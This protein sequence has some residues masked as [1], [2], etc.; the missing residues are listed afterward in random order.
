MRGQLTR[1]RG[2]E[3][4][5]LGDGF[6]TTFDGPA[7]AIRC[8]AAIARE[9]A[10]LGLFVRAGLHTGEVELAGDDIRGIAVHAASR[11]SAKA[12]PGEVWTTRTVRDLVAGSGISFV[13]RGT[14]QLKGLREAMPL[15]A[16]T[17]T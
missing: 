16:A 8:A 14:H 2:K 13:D 15:F 3:V 17:V 1:F 10:S 9:T 6:L 11:V 4:K 7:R 12:A 5:S